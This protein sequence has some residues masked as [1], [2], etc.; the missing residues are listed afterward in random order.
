MISNPR[1]VS[2]LHMGVR[3]ERR[4]FRDVAV[5][6]FRR[7]RFTHQEIEAAFKPVF[8]WV[9]QDARSQIVLNLSGIQALPSVGFC[10]LLRLKRFAEE[11]GGRLVLC[12]LPPVIQE[13]MEYTRLAT[14]FQIYA[15]EEEAL[16]SFSKDRHL[17]GR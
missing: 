8:Q 9:E 16:R 5:V 4:D 3:S 2:A 11:A 17:P 10:L 15:T 1:P 13:A 12:H 14:I 7:T 6:R